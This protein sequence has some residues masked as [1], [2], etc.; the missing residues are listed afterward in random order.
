MAKCYHKRRHHLVV[1]SIAAFATGFSCGLCALLPVPLSKTIARS[2]SATSDR[3]PLNNSPF[4]ILPEPVERPLDRYLYKRDK[5]YDRIVPHWELQHRTMEQHKLYEGD[6]SLF[7]KELTD[8]GAVVQDITTGAF[9]F[10]PEADFGT[11]GADMVP[12][13]IVHGA[14]CTYMDTTVIESPD[15]TMLR[16]QTGIVYEWDEA[17][18]EG[19]ILPSEGQNAFR[20]IRA[21]RR[22]IRWHDSRRLFPGQ[23]V[24]FET[25]LP[26]EVNVP[27]SNDPQAPVALR[28]RGLEV[29]FSLQTGHE[30][31]EEG[32]RASVKPAMLETGKDLTATVQGQ[33]AREEFPVGLAMLEPR[34]DL[35][36]EAS[37]LAQR[38]SL[39]PSSGHIVPQ[40]QS[41]QRMHP[42]LQRFAEETPEVAQAESP[43]WLWEPQLHYLKEE[44]YDPI[45][46]L[47][48]REPW[49]KTPV[50][51]IMT[52]EVAIERGDAWREPAFREY[53]RQMTKIKPRGRKQAEIYSIRLYELARQKKNAEIRS[54]KQRIATKQKESRGRLIDRL[55]TLS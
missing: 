22:D 35:P 1:L 44:R 42:V 5:H 32:T 3:F 40:R 8:E 14:K 24:Q 34:D 52:H 45:L 25:A 17:T 33:Q 37:Y 2:P 30:L 29:R 53:H 38:D 18:G 11:I 12:G 6:F 16:L 41:K 21:L 47:K 27:D 23:F 20:M 51:R 39:P 55:A 49:Q 7:I 46:P 36:S 13:D 54:V 43:C 48:L 26:D 15:P 9:G 31:I 28:L 50:Q 10:V 4:S 19:Y